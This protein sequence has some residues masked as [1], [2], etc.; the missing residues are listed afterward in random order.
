MNKYSTI[1]FDWS[2]V[3]ADDS[4]DEFVNQ[5]LKSVGATDYQAKEIIETYFVDFLKGS[6]SEVKFWDKLKTNYGFN[7][8]K[9][10][11]EEFKKWQGLIANNDILK[12]I[13]KIK[14]R[15]FKVAVLT[16]IIKPVYDIIQQTGSY[17]VFDE[18]IASCEVGLAKP[19]EEIYEIALKRLGVSAQ[20]SIFIDDKKINIE[21]ANKIGFK[22]ILAQSPDQIIHD[23]EKII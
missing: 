16:N 10:T 9:P 20:Q 17:D 1:F 12:L 11:S 3:I 6:F 2:G 13:Y 5:L 22:T 15:G 21:T 23:L 8:T 4:G 19:Q 7:I 14:S 18:V